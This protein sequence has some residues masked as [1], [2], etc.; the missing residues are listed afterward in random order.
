MDLDPLLLA[1]GLAGFLAV[2]LLIEALYHHWLDRHSDAAKRI[3]RRLAALDDDA[4]VE[5]L[6]LRLGAGR[7]R[8]P[9]LEQWVSSLDIG[10]RLS[11]YVAVAGLRSTAADLLLLSGTLAL[12]AFLL[13]VML[14][15]SAGISVL[16]GLTLAGVPWW[17]VYARYT[18]RTLEF[19]RQFPEALG[20][21]GRALRAG[22]AMPMALR[23]CANELPEPLRDEFRTLSDEITYGISLTHALHGLADRVPVPDMNYF[24]VAVTIQRETGGNLAELLD[25]IER[26]VVQRQK[27][28]DKVRTLTAEGR[29]SSWVLAVM[30]FGVVGLI[31]LVNAEYVRPLFTTPGGHTMLS[32]SLTLIVIGV[33]WMKF[34]VRTKV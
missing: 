6:S 30:P 21:L 16:I 10:V 15:A 3:A 23:M 22:H 1:F 5:S 8:W 34:L 7:S 17:R 14:G 33:A 18:A 31:S 11:R 28:R 4:P 26:L 2:A 27:L 9:A 12:V 19:D 20:L 13:L 32:I 24:V 25:S 29:L